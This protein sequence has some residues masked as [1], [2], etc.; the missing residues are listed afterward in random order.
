M[1]AGTHTSDVVQAISEA[2]AKNQL[3]EFEV[4]VGAAQAHGATLA[5]YYGSESCH[6][7]INK[8]ASADAD[9]YSR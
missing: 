4:Q 1:P 5:H 9:T 6:P 7:Y 2:D 3:L 8:A